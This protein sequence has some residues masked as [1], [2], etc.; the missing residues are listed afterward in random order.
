[1]REVM[2]KCAFQDDLLSCRL[3]DLLF[4]FHVNVKL[5]RVLFVLFVLFV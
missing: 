1:V 3:L 4:G 2:Y 5:N